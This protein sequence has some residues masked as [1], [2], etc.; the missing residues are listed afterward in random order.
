MTYRNL[1]TPLEGV[2]FHLDSSKEFMSKSQGFSEMSPE[3]VKSCLLML[4]LSLE[5]QTQLN[6]LIVQAVRDLETKKPWYRR[7]IK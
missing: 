6:Y 4:Q 2:E 7:F 1:S 5:K 3:D